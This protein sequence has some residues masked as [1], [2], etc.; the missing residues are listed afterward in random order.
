[1][2]IH[3]FNQ[4]KLNVKSVDLIDRQAVFTPTTN[5]G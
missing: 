2:M 3:L 1:M 4:E 5:I